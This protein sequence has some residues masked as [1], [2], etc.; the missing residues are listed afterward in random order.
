MSHPQEPAEDAVG[1][2]PESSER[3]SLADA[4]TKHGGPGANPTSVAP[5]SPHERKTS[6]DDAP[7]VRPL[8]K[9]P[10]YRVLG[11]LGR[12]G[13]GVVYKAEQIALSRIVALK[14]LTAGAHA[15]P[16]ELA[17][18]R[19]E[20]ESAARLAHPGI[21]QVY[22]VG[23]SDGCP[24]FSLEFVA[25]GTLGER[26]RAQPLS[27]REAAQLIVTIARAVQFAHEQEIIHRDLK[28]AN[29]LL[30]PKGEPKI[31]DFGLAKRLSGTSQTKTGEVMGTPGYMAPEQATGVTKT[32]GPACDVYALGAI[33]YELLTG[34]PPFY[35]PDPVETILQVIS[36]EPV[37]VHRLAPSTPRDLATICHKCLEKPPK[38][39][40]AS[41][42]EFADDLERFLSDQPILARPTPS[43]ERV[44][45]WVK[46]RPAVAGM[47]GVVIVAL[48]TIF[49]YHLWKNRQLSI[50]LKETQKQQARAEDNLWFAVEAA[51]RR[52]E[53]AGEPAESLLREELKF[54]SYMRRYTDKDPAIA[55]ERG[56]AAWKMGDIHRLLLE[57]ELADQAY[58][59]ADQEFALLAKQFPENLKY[60]RGLAGV[61]NGRGRLR[62]DQRNLQAAESEYAASEKIFREL[63]A[64]DKN[65]PDYARQCA[66]VLNNQSFLAARQGKQD[67]ALAR[68]EESVKLRQALVAFGPKNPEYQRE[69][70]LG[71][72]N[73]NGLLTRIKPPAEALKIVDETLRGLSELPASEQSDQMV[74]EVKV[75]THGNRAFVLSKL[76]RDSE[77]ENE[78]RES[79]AAIAALHKDY[80]EL[81]RYEQGLADAN[82]NL[83]MH[84]A[85]YAHFKEAVGPMSTAATI[86]SELAGRHP[87]SQEFKQATSELPA[88]VKDLQDAAEAAEKAP[89]KSAGATP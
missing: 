63:M 68:Q 62:A 30:T 21:V 64:A 4:P 88:L 16:S 35:D 40:Y 70:L 67:E 6:P 81:V 87:E 38:K 84:L 12:G 19:S 47:I 20:A 72:A 48:V 14:V 56:I 50:A 25:G 49:S 79:I 77:A 37:S 7:Q 8:P 69:L 43:W 80:P 42:G 46:R 82:K 18:F 53:R 65:D 10:G 32:I 9:L 74:R 66:A 59:E 27:P 3:E 45:K 5:T 73:R 78:Y 60:P 22:E 86:Y 13:M 36:D 23:E 51:G 1:L 58:D 41:A 24:Y 52:I 33:L 89:A 85:A 75:A 71:Y 61:H 39:R 26:L 76:L 29:V 28:P 34:R 2:Q 15:S 83:A 31:A 55:Y 17:R 11:E 54:F 57:T 44:V